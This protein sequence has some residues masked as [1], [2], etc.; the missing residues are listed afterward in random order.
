MYVFMCVYVNICAV[1]VAQNPVDFYAE[2]ES[3]SFTHSHLN[4]R[5]CTLLNDS[6]DSGYQLMAV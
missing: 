6:F 1:N 5:W 3:Q 4:C 2:G